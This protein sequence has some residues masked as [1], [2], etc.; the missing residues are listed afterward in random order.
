MH[1]KSIIQR[2]QKRPRLFFG[3]GFPRKRKLLGDFEGR[4]LHQ[5]VLKVLG[6]RC[7]TKKKKKMANLTARA[8]EFKKPHRPTLRSQCAMLLWLLFLST[9]VKAFA[10]VVENVK[11]FGSMEGANRVMHDEQAWRRGADGFVERC[12]QLSEWGLYN[13]KEACVPNGLD[14][15]PPFVDPVQL[16][17]MVTRC[18]DTPAFWVPCPGFEGFP[19]PRFDFGSFSV[20]V[21]VAMSELPWYL[22]QTMQNAL[23]FTSNSTLLI[24]HLDAHTKYP[25]FGVDADFDWL[26]K[27]HRLVVSCYRTP[28]ARWHGSILLA[29]ISTAQLAWCL[30]ADAEHVVQQASNMWW[31]GTGMEAYVQKHHS[32][33]S[34]LLPPPPADIRIGQRH[35]PF[36]KYN[37][38]EVISS[39]GRN[40]QT[41]GMMGCLR[42]PL[43]IGDHPDPMDGKPCGLPDACR[44]PPIKGLGFVV[45]AKHEGAFYPARE[46]YRFTRYMRP[47]LENQSLGEEWK[48]ATASLH[49][50]NKKQTSWLSHFYNE[51]HYMEELMLQSWMASF[52]EKGGTGHI[53]CAG[54]DYGYSWGG[55]HLHQELYTEK[56]GTTPC[57]Y[58]TLGFVAFAVKY[59]NIRDEKHQWLRDQI[60][61]CAKGSGGNQLI[62]D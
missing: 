27:Q 39:N 5:R 7:L 26:W 51:D 10:E 38:C 12:M 29:H 3:R 28:T 45:Q 16:A 41:Y 33:S 54:G 55:G 49:C 15:I 17:S 23:W 62:A 32:S 53:L 22:R 44:V 48:Q 47:M 34:K 8:W 30:G 4:E 24:L 11:L 6:L 2:H 21:S 13:R 59:H 14:P 36:N 9:F 61:S 18:P 56:E 25:E 58:E 42:L 37:D 60:N 40:G 46:I 20:V 19:S 50:K 57:P 31:A 1:S 43:A 35:R 52:S